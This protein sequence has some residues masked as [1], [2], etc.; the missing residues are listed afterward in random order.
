MGTFSP[1][2]LANQVQQAS[3]VSWDNNNNRESLASVLEKSNGNTIHIHM[4][5]NG[6]G[7]GGPVNC[8]GF[9]GGAYPAGALGY[10]PSVVPTLPGMWPLPPLSYGNGYYP[11]GFVFGC[12]SGPVLLPPLVNQCGGTVPAG[13]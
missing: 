10:P 8:G 5:C 6:S 1:A 2:A 4:N 12:P 3:D 9:P 7:G 13:W 11:P